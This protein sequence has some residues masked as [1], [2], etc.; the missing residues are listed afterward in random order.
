MDEADGNSSY[1]VDIPDGGVTYLIGNLIQQGP[2]TENSSMVA[3][4]AESAS[5]PLQQ[6][7]VVNNTLVNDR[8]SGT[9]LSIRSG[10]TARITNNLF[11]G[12]GTT[13]GGPGGNVTNLQTNS[14]ALLSQGGY[15]YR[16]TATSPAR[17]V[18]SD[19]GSVNGV[20][21]TPLYQY[22]HNAAREPRPGQGTIDIGAYE[23]AP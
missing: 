16:L 13:I 4:A 10:T 21:L 23:Y 18:G 15:D 20:A 7:Y 9:F 19:P 2:N 11:V 14:P 22:R 3:Y 6:L 5:N 8:G 1:A 17:D 12:N